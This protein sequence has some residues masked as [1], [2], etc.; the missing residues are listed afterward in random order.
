MS[1]YPLPAGRRLVVQQRKL[2][3]DSVGQYTMRERKYEIC[4]GKNLVE[5]EVREG[6][7]HWYHRNEV[8]GMLEGAG[9][10]DIK[11]TGNFTHE[12]FTQA[13]TDEMVFVATR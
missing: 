12:A 6:S 13:H 7:T 9:F 3:E 4:D 11:V 1:D 2:F 10:S 5:E 8:L